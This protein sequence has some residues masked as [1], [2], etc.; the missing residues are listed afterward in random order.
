M[1]FHRLFHMNFLL[2]LLVPRPEHCD[3]TQS[4]CWCPGYLGHQSI[5]PSDDYRVT[6][7]DLQQ[8]HHSYS[9]SWVTLKE[10]D[11]YQIAKNMEKVRAVHACFF[12]GYTLC[13]CGSHWPN[14]SSIC[15]SSNAF[16]ESYLSNCIIV[17]VGFTIFS[18]LSIIHW[19]GTQATVE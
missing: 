14:H 12:F 1:L 7:P 11:L 5:R 8:S 10:N 3:T 16:T 2:S 9:S 13:P 17:G 6:S 18:T 19:T 15:I 4:A